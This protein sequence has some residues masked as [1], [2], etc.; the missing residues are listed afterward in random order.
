MIPRATINQQTP[1]DVW[2]WLQ[3]SGEMAATFSSLVKLYGQNP[4]RFYQLACVGVP[5]DAPAWAREIAD[6]AAMV[7]YF[8]RFGF[9][10]DDRLKQIV[11]AEKSLF[12]GDSEFEGALQFLRRLSGTDNIPAGRDYYGKG[13]SPAE[14]L[15]NVGSSDE[16]QIDRSLTVARKTV[17][18]RLLHIDEQDIE[19]I[20]HGMPAYVIY[21]LHN[22]AQRVIQAPTV[23]F[24]GIRRRGRLIAGRAYCGKPRRA[25]GNDGRA[26]SA[27][28]GMVYCVYVDPENFVFD[29]DWVEEDPTRP[30]YPQGYRVRFANQITDFSE[31]VLALPSELSPEAF[32]K[33]RAWHSFRGDCMFFYASDAPAYA[34]RVN[35]ELTEYRSIGS[36]ELVGCKV[37]NF[38]ELL[39]KVTHSPQ[40]SSVP[41]SAVLAA[42]L[43]RQMDSLQQREKAT[44]IRLVFDAAFRMNEEH[45][46]KFF[47]A[48]VQL[49]DQA[50]RYLQAVCDMVL[51]FTQDRAHPVLVYAAQALA[52]RQAIEEPYLRLITAAGKTTVSAQTVNAV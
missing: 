43:V 35:E 29:W 25:F 8:I 33:A 23:V 13:V 27:P 11:G 9:Q 22:C 49:D 47:S 5:T 18:P 17:K 7:R 39:S 40:S 42:S 45:R 10:T 28:S 1:A 3:A 32:K 19:A 50:E 26:V 34:K 20:R 46:R 36:G 2:Q 16:D 31:T 24:Q 30:G 37:K 38:E 4:D 12:L 21:E 52:S 6:L 14:V 44:F 48:L 15:F 51:E 41:V